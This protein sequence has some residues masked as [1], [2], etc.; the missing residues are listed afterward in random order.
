MNVRG[1]FHSMGNAIVKEKTGLQITRESAEHTLAMWDILSTAKNLPPR[2][3]EEGDGIAANL[4]G[5]L[6]NPM[7]GNKAIEWL[8]SDLNWI[9]TKGK[10]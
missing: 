9:L 2:W 7:A 3:K 4:R 6:K 5:T 10:L 1:Y 8:Q